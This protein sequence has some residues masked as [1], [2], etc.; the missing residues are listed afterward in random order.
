MRSYSPMDNLE[1]A[2]DRVNTEHRRLVSTRLNSNNA[3]LD[4][5]RNFDDSIA[6]EGGRIVSQSLGD[7]VAGSLVERP[8]RVLEAK[9]QS[10]A[11]PH[12]GNA[13]PDYG[14]QANRSDFDVF[15][16]CMH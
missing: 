3:K 6:K 1:V 12:S 2:W 8:C 9:G 4:P 15:L 5:P 13:L 16:A 14:Y 7:S 11:L 10:K